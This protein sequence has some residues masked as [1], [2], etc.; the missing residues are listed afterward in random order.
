MKYLSFFI[1]FTGISY[2]FT[3]DTL[4]MLPDF[5]QAKGFKSKLKTFSEEYVLLQFWSPSCEP[6]GTE[7]KEINDSLKFLNKKTKTLGALGIPIDGRS[8]EI[9]A[10]VSHFEPVYVQW[11]PDEESKTTIRKKAKGVPWTLL[12][13]KSQGFIKEWTGK[14]TSDV[15]IST[16]QKEEGKN[17]NEK[18][19]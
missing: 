16:I 14:I 19:N 8:Q 18:S 10:F 3:D 1:F 15:V 2:G 5:L 9:E 12:L 4:K 6:C 7:V 11:N 17:S 13:K